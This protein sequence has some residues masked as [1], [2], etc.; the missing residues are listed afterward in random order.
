MLNQSDGLRS[1]NALMVGAGV[2]TGGQEIISSGGF[3]RGALAM[4]LSAGLCLPLAACG[5][6]QSGAVSNESEGQQA[7]VSASAEGAEVKTPE[8]VEEQRV[9]VWEHYP[10]P[11]TPAGR[12]DPLPA[13]ALEKPTKY[14]PKKFPNT[15]EGKEAFAKYFLETL[16]LESH[17]LNFAMTKTLYKDCD[18]CEEY[19]VGAI[20]ASKSESF[21]QLTHIHSITKVFRIHFRKSG[22]DSFVLRIDNESNDDNDRLRDFRVTVTSRE[23]LME[24]SDLASSEEYRS[25]DPTDR[26]VELD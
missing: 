11:E 26:V 16:I 2:R 1:E 5:T 25:V 24:V 14:D 4:L 12:K 8:G 9:F 13:W 23:G 17:T 22:D 20:D 19:I 15:V 3:R 7:T 6:T 10:T 21:I 18:S